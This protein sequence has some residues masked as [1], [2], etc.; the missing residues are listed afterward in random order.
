MIL[1]YEDKKTYSDNVNDKSYTYN[2][3]HATDISPSEFHLLEE[4]YNA[5]HSGTVRTLKKVRYNDGKI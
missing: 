4:K 3:I 5:Y 1:K 2:E